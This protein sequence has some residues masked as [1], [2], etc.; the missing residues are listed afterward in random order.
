MTVKTISDINNL[1]YLIKHRDNNVTI[2]SEILI[3]DYDISLLDL[4]NMNYKIQLEDRLFNNSS[5]SYQLVNLKTNEIELDDVSLQEILD[6]FNEDK[7]SFH[8]GS[9]IR[10]YIETN[11]ITIKEFAK[12]SDLSTDIIWQLVSDKIDVDTSIA[13][14]LE[15][16][17]G[18]S[19]NT[20]V[21]LQQSYEE[22]KYEK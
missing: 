19:L 15:K 17:T 2:V 18:I 22:S 12:K 6:Y 11:N 21:N 9:Y 14:S 4:N 3:D 13:L 1:G 16:A 20:W 8:P 10:S 5:I 7:I